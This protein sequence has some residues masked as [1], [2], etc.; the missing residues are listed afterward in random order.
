MG[1]L[2]DYSEGSS[3]FGRV[4]YVV[5]IP[6]LLCAA[7]YSD[8]TKTVK[9]R[10][11]LASYQWLLPVYRHL[12]V[13]FIKYMSRNYKRV[14][15]FWQKSVAITCGVTHVKNELT[16]TGIGPDS[17][18]GIATGHGLDGPGIESRWGARFSAPVQTDLEAHPASCTMG[19]GSFPEVKSGRGVTLTPHLLLVPWSRK[20]RATPPIGRTACTEPQCLYKGALYLSF[21]FNSCALRGH[22]AAGS[23]NL[24][25]TFRDKL[26][27]PY[28][29]VNSSHLK[30]GPI[31]CPETSVINY[32]N[33]P[34]NDP[35]ERSSHLLRSG[36][37]ISSLLEFRSWNISYAGVV[38]WRNCSTCL[39]QNKVIS[40]SLLLPVDVWNYSVFLLTQAC[41]PYIVAVS[42]PIAL[43]AVRCRVQM[44]P[45]LKI[46][47]KCAVEK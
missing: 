4:V 5:P 43:S 17:S 1:N 18:V 30:T 31:G 32:H 21:Y 35:E 44:S 41:A 12:V 39:L 28:S 6:C 7:Q 26:W 40:V 22:Y 19:T 42:L 13:I 15:T 23:G 47:D 20:S 9:T 14:A 3:E 46:V 29:W 8:G 37:L 25:P 36:R 11:P 45:V 16:L 27:V 38:A 24:L 2:G 10:G 34:R 33:S